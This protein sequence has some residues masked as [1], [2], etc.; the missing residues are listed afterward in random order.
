MSG[1]RPSS[2][3]I[4][5]REIAE[6]VDNWL[7]RIPQL[8]GLFAALAMSGRVGIFGGFVRDRIHNVIHG[9][10]IR[11][12]DLDLVVDGALTIQAKG[13]ETNNFG[14]NRRWLA[15]D[16]KVDYWELRQTYA[17]RKGLLKPGFEALP[18]TTVYTANACLF[19]ISSRQL[20]ECG[21][22]HDISRRI[23]AFNCRDYLNVF[24]EYQAFRAIELAKRLGYQLHHDVLEFVVLQL[25]S[26]TWINF[27]R[28][29]Q[30]HRREISTEELRAL[31]ESYLPLV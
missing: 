31:C 11:P 27:V 10:K 28:A 15:P 16:L 6:D 25:R 2:R 29:V 24:P 30:Q 26:S 4:L 7:R 1:L 13:E 18:R 19:E 3:P 22:I 17:F 8:A 21:A 23:I 9:E 20:I 5:E 14:G 12:R